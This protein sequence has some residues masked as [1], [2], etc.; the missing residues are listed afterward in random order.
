MLDHI[1][2]ILR[3]TTSIGHQGLIKLGCQKLDEELVNPTQ[4]DKDMCWYM[5]EMNK[6]LIAVIDWQTAGLALL[7]FTAGSSKFLSCCSRPVT[8][9]GC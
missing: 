2:S 6:F 3:K 8:E 1:D 9:S 5:M 7:L 4:L